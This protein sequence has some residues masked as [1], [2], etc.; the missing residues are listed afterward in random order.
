MLIPSAQL[1]V[2]SHFSE[3]R[4]YAGFCS[5]IKMSCL[6][7]RKKEGFL[8]TTTVFNVLFCATEFLGDFYGTLLQRG[9]YPNFILVLV[10]CQ[11]I[12]MV[13]QQIIWNGKNVLPWYKMKMFRQMT[14]NLDNCSHVVIVYL[15]LSH[16][17]VWNQRLPA[18]SPHPK[19]H[20]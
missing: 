15:S 18:S 20:P 12:K 6:T 7:I 16:H 4:V 19:T 1:E 9:F 2:M 3:G 14:N 10:S 17:F 5:N 11:T 13:Q 8:R